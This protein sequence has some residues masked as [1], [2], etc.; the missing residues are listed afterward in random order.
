[1]SFETIVFPPLLLPLYTTV[2]VPTLR[3]PAIV[4]TGSP[5][6]PVRVSVAAFKV[7]VPPDCR[8]RLPIVGAKF[9]AVV[10]KVPAVS[11]STFVMVVA[12]AMDLVP[13]P[14]IFKL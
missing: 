1:M 13:V 14:E 3:V 10:V 12:M 9:E 8:S 4:S 5:S 7:R 6:V 2:E 11:V